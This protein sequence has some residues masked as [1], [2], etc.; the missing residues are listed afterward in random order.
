LAKA[1]FGQLSEDRG[2]AV[3]GW[4]E[5]FRGESRDRLACARRIVVVPDVVN[6]GRQGT[7]L[8]IAIDLRDERGVEGRSSDR[9]PPPSGSKGSE[10]SA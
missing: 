4:W 10:V 5:L 3:A 1:V 7:L 2:I 6:V 8:E 9:I